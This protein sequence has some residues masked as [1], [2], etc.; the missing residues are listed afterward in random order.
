MD[1]QAFWGEQ[2]AP[3]REYIFAARDRMDE[4]FD[5][6]RAVRD[7]RF[8]YIRN[9][10]Q[11]FGAYLD[12]GYR[13]QLKTMQVMLEMRDA[14]TL[15][16]DQKYWFRTSKEAEE[17]YDLQNDP[18]ELHN[19]AADPSFASELDRLRKVHEEWVRA[20]DDKGVKHLTEKELLLEMWPDGKQPETLA[21]EIVMD[22]SLVNIT[23]AT[24]GASIVYQINHKGLNDKH[25]YLYSRPFELVSGDTI[26]AIAH[27][28]GYKESQPSEL[29]HLK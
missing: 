5:C 3:P 18:H 29:V 25:W 24:E 11:E 7:T 19:L 26:S 28:I 2:K 13:K 9:Y 23:S 14:G 6:R 12:I 15:N 4:W 22:K 27:R 8:K 16:E 20:I 21:P 1:G 10:R 17:L